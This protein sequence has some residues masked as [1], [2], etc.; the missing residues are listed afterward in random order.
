[1]VEHD[2][3]AALAGVAKAPSHTPAASNVTV[4]N[5]FL[6]APSSLNPWGAA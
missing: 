2:V 4:A 6:I 1:M 5:L 3:V